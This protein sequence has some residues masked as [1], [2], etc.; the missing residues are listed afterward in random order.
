MSKNIKM[1][2]L[3]I[4]VYLPVGVALYSHVGK[5]KNRFDFVI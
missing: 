1:T 2:W 3:Q 4:L 5:E